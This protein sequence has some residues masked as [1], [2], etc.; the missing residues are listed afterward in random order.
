MRFAA[1][2]GAACRL[3]DS[4]DFFIRRFSSGSF[5]FFVPKIAAK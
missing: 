1:R 4:F 5:F 2:P 3:C